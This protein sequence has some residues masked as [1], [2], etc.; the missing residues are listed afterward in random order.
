MVERDPQPADV[1]AVLFAR[2]EEAIA[3]AD[4]LRVE[5][6]VLLDISAALRDGRL[7]SRCAWCGRYRVGERWMI[8]AELP[9]L[10]AYAG[11]THTICDQC[12]DLLQKRGLSV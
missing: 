6:E 8:V 10:V 1:Q 2:I 11:T 4:R 9:Q 3:A 7:T 12:V 5:S